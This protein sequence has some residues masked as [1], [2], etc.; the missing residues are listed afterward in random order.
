M[1]ARRC[2]TRSAFHSDRRYVG[3]LRRRNA[4]RFS[5]LRRGRTVADWS[6]CADRLRA[7]WQKSFCFFFFRKRRLFG[8]LFTPTAR[9]SAHC[10]G[11]MRCAFPPYGATVLPSIEDH[12][13]S[14]EQ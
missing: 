1:I 2:H 5:A 10:V 14:R 6:E 7:N 8:L 12:R 11:G 4:L 3:T 13:S 9:T